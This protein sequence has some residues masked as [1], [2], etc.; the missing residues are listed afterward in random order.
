[1]IQDDPSQR[2]RWVVNSASGLPDSLPLVLAAA[3]YK[4]AGK[5]LQRQSG[6]K[7]PYSNN[8]IVSK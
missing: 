8:P 5:S 7:P 2:V 6:D 3:F 4:S 1:M